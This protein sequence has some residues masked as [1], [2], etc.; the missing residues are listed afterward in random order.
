MKVPTLKQARALRD[1]ARAVGDWRMVELCDIA[2]DGVQLGRDTTVEDAIERVAYTIKM[3]TSDSLIGFKAAQM[4]WANVPDSSPTV[5]MRWE[6]LETTLYVDG[7]TEI[8]SLTRPGM[9]AEMYVDKRRGRPIGVSV[10]FSATSGGGDVMSR[11]MAHSF[12]AAILTRVALT[13]PGEDAAGIDVNQ[14]WVL[15]GVSCRSN[16]SRHVGAY[17]A[18]VGAVEAVDA[19]F[20]GAPGATVGLA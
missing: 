14:T 3:A 15:P 12:V 1:E 7:K 19:F 10:S 16:G 17:V 2:I 18:G 5:S 20:D 9:R 6:V 4:P 11:A 13:P 8:V